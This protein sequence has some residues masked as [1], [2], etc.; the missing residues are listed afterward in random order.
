MIA[1]RMKPV[2]LAAAFIAAFASTASARDRLPGDGRPGFG[3]HER[4][5]GHG[6]HGRRGDLPLLSDHRLGGASRAVSS[7][8]QRRYSSSSINTFAPIGVV[9]GSSIFY[10]DGY[11]EI[12]LEPG[13]TGTRPPAARNIAPKAKVIDV[14]QEVVDGSFRPVNGCVH[15]MG[16]CVIRGGN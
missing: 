4:H 2:L 3:H 11:R 8:S 1:N 12:Y 14:T 5:R 10:S 7:T 16:V 15:E 9:S 6:H 13:T